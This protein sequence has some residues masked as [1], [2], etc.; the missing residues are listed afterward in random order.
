MS[1]DL[2]FDA[3]DVFLPALNENKPPYDEVDVSSKEFWLTTFEE[4]EKS[5]AVLRRERPVS[6]Q[7]PI[8]DA[9]LPDPDDPGYWAIVRHADITKIS[10]TNELFI[11]GQGILFDVMPQAMLEMSQSIVSMDDPRHAN[12]RRLVSAAFTPKQVRRMEAKV[13]DAARELVDRIASRGHAE[14]VAEITSPLPAMVVCDIFG[15]PRERWDDAAHFARNVTNWA[16][17]ECLQGRPADEMVVEACV[18]LHA[19]AEE[20][21]E[22]RRKEPTE[23][24]LQALIDAEIDGAKLDDFEIQAFFTLMICAG[25]DTTKHSL[26]HSLLGLTTFPDQRKWLMEDFDGRIDVAID[27]FLRYATPIMNFRRTVKAETTFGGQRMMP[28]DKVVMFYGSGN[29]D[30][31]VFTD[32][33]SLILDRSPNPQLSFG[34]GGVHFCLG[35][36][37][38]KSMIKAMLRQ[39]LTRLPDFEAHSAVMAETNFMRAFNRLELRFTP[40]AT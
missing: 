15:V 36:Q 26:G 38:A 8:E 30:T 3:S 9:V 34:G 32:P 16:D 11:S 33:D 17:P 31:E 4:R 25:T 24:L 14:A 13:L 21:I 1:T 12:L 40:E 35:N 18:E 22:E 28:G 23:D 6:W 37:L 39:I 19:M 10:K 20:M 29:W 5:F 7:R 27:E 2:D